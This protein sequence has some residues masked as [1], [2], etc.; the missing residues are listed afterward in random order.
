MRIYNLL[1]KTEESY[2]SFMSTKQSDPHH[3]LSSSDH[4]MNICHVIM[5][6]QIYQFLWG[7][8]NFGVILGSFLC[9][10]F[11]QIQYGNS[12]ILIM[13]RTN[14]MEKHVQEPISSA[15]RLSE[16]L[17]AYRLVHFDFHYDSRI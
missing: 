10:Q 5:L 1:F 4:K 9:L 3:C 15:E 6:I 14:V 16:Q 2:P 11:C 8:W 7:F 13:W 17:F 12:D